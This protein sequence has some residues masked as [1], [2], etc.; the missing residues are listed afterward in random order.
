MVL[1]VNF[2]GFKVSEIALNKHLPIG[3]LSR[4]VPALLSLAV[5]CG[6]AQANDPDFRYVVKAG[7]NPWNLTQRYL[8]SIDY[9]PRIQTYNNIDAPTRI[10]PGTVLNIPTAWMRSDSVSARVTDLHGTVIAERKGEKT[11]LSTGAA[12]A[13]G[14]VIR[15]SADS[16]FTVA[17]PDGSTTLIGADAEVRLK[18]AAK[19]RAGGAQHVELD[20]LDGEL[21]NRVTS[22]HQGG[23]RF[24]IHTPSAVAAVR[25]TDFRAAADSSATRIETLTGEVTLSNKRGNV[26]LAAGS[27]SRVESGNKPDSAASLLP[28]PDLSPLPSRIERM[29]F[30][31]ALPVV[32][33]AQG[34]RSQIAPTSGFSVIQSDRTSLVAAAVGGGTLPDGHY[35]IRVRAIDGRGIEGLD[36]EAG[37]EIDARPE[38]PF[39]TTP[40]PDGV[41]S[42]NR[43]RFGWAGVPESIGYHFELA[44]DREFSSK[45]M[46]RDD[47]S[48][49]GLS[50]DVELD[51]GEYF[52]RVAVSTAQEGRGPF[53]DPQRFRRLAAG[54]APETSTDAGQMS[55]RWRAIPTASAYRVQI[56]SS[57]DF[58]APEHEL[59][60]LEPLIAIDTPP[61]GI[62]FVRVRH[63]E[64]DGAMGPW[65]PAQTVEVAQSLWPALLFTVPLLFLL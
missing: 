60:T 42:D 52:W 51:A 39:P 12:I 1:D 56:S 34:Y 19:V 55:L 53:S 8:K 57:A 65:G 28:A 14:S 4:L 30:D 54:P 43:I 10:P 17:F 16:S 21:E 26:K 44:S 61:P 35:R 5:L 32:E 58:A 63:V 22:R 40:I 2:G 50:L 59:E 38:P 3:C 46:S 36:A 45:I 47:L 23:G 7:D 11:V 13:P 37:I 6:P 33:G 9:W 64:T 20:L 27:G 62:Y 18:R 48:E 15:T 24:L 49:S 25:G 41:A 31:H 29:P